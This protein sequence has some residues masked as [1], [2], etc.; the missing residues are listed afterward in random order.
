MASISLL[1]LVSFLCI[2]IHGCFGGDAP[3]VNAT[4]SPTAP[5]LPCEYV[6]IGRCNH[7][8]KNVFL[9][10]KRRAIY[11]GRSQSFKDKKNVYCQALQTFMDCLWKSLKKCRGGT[12]LAQ[13]SLVVLEHGVMDKKCAVCRRHR[14]R[15]LEKALNG[16]DTCPA[17]A[18]FVHRKCVKRFL[19]KMTQDTNMCHDVQEFIAC[20]V[21]EGDPKKSSCGLERIVK[22]FS[23]LCGQLGKQMLREDEI[24]PGLMC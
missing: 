5:R 24:H 18:R 1:L 22:N 12:W 13:Y 15:K 21:E 20:Y 6:A 9:I 17:C 8:F 11:A 10:A 4:F 3:T 14:V 16:H 19:D 2:T 23:R 7:E